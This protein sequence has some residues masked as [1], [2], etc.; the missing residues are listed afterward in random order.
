MPSP[1]ESNDNSSK[2]AKEES[3][4]RKTKDSTSSK[5]ALLLALVTSWEIALILRRIPASS[6]LICQNQSFYSLFEVNIICH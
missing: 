2:G 3:F 5:W 4:K 1:L 6:P